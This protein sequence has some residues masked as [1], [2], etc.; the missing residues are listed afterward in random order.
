MYKYLGGQLSG[1]VGESS[2]CSFDF[3]PRY[4]FVESQKI[5]GKREIN[6][7]GFFVKLFGSRLSV[8]K[9]SHDKFFFESGK[10]GFEKKI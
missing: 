10:L 5:L 4:G 6:I 1:L 8:E 2:K 7:F 9:C 3:K